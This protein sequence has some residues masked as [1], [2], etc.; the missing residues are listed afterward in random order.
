MVKYSVWV[1]LV[2]DACDTATLLHS[3]LLERLALVSVTPPPPHLKTNLNTSHRDGRVQ[4]AAPPSTGA[5][6]PFLR[7]LY[8][9]SNVSHGNSLLLL[10]LLFWTS[11]FSSSIL[12]LPSSQ[13]KLYRLH[14][15]DLCTLSMPSFLLTPVLRQ[16]CILCQIGMTIPI[17][18]ALDDFVGW[19]ALPTF[20]FKRPVFSYPRARCWSRTS[21]TAVSLE[22]LV[23]FRCSCKVLRSR[24][25][26]AVE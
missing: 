25:M 11:S 4:T 23:R 5:K 14:F 13:L 24:G 20:E 18:F 16:A 8:A 3:A 19:N 15:S 1:C 9:S 7:R 10:L 2:P 12:C 17:G 21:A 22:R 26:Y 6:Y